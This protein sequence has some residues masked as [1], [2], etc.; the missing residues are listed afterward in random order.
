MLRAEALTHNLATMAGWCRDRGVELAPHG[1]TH[2]APQLLAR[3]FEAGACAVTV[4]TISQARVY[5]AF[6]VRDFILA[7]ELVDAA[8][9]RWVAAECDAD[10]D[11]TLMCWVD[12]R[13]GR[14]TDGVRRSRRPG[15]TA[16]RRLRRSRHGRG[17]HRLP[18][19]IDAST[20]WRAPPRTARRCGWSAWRATR[21]R[22]ATT[23]RPR[24]W[25]AS[26]PTWRSCGRP[27]SGWPTC[28]KP[29]ASS[30][31]PAAALTSTRSPMCWPSGG[32]RADVRTIIRSGCYLTH[33]HGL[34]ARTSPLARS[35]S[36]ARGV[37]AGGVAAGARIWRC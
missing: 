34:Y 23:S 31:P 32:R 3:Q 12:S 1:K 18:R 5:R 28:S 24:H 20:R 21:R 9:L 16:G 10:P 33:D 19:R 30:S 17:S 2:M 26:P 14:A 37:G 27:S 35:A 22:S 29:T 8:G 25:P 7:N 36:G 4:A 11:F 13:R 15:A 6:G